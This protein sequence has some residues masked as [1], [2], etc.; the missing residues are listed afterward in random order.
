MSQIIVIYLILFKAQSKKINVIDLHYNSL[1]PQQCASE[2][3]WQTW[4]TSL[5]SKF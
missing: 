3:K 2:F 5:K 4:L 1:E